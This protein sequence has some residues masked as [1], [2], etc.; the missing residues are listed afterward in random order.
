MPDNE[1]TAEQ[2]DA[3]RPG[4]D[5]AWFD[6]GQAAQHYPELKPL[7]GWNWWW[8]GTGQ[9]A[10]LIGYRYVPERGIDMMYVEAD[11]RAAVTRANPKHELYLHE[12]GELSEVLAHVLV[13][14]D[15]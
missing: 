5:Y 6:T 11:R 10:Q 12:V 13:G 8:A 15:A 14:E 3:K 4:G 9:A 2:A 7:T 1:E